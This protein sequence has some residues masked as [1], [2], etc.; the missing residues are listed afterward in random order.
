MKNIL[1]ILGTRP[2]AIKLA[3]VILE[4]QGQKKYHITICNTEQQKELSNQTLGFFGIQA[5]IYLDCM[6]PNQSLANLQSKILSAL[7][8]V[9]QHRVYHASI[10]Q[11]D[12]MSAFCGAL[13]SFY[14]HVPLFHVEAGL[15][16][17][18]M[19]EPFPEE[20]LRQMISK[21]ATLHFTPTNLA[22]ALL[23]QEGITAQSIIETG[24]T[25]LDALFCLSEESLQRAKKFWEQ[26]GIPLQSSARDGSN[27]VLITTHRRENHG[28]RLEEI[29]KAIRTLA[30]TF[31]NHYFIIPVHPNPNVKQRIYRSLS[32][33]ANILLCEPLDYPNLVLIMQHSKL[34]LTD[35]GGIQEEAPSFGV[36]IL[37]MRHETERKE[38][39]Q[40][41]FAKLVGT[42]SLCIVKE[43]SEILQRE[44]T[45][46]PKPNPYGNGEARVKIAQG[47]DTFFAPPPVV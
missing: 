35:S 4:L 10:V 33:F 1:I 15:R 36:P 29:L 23:L 20:A 7:E 44:T 28:D 47:I 38:G 18:N 37:V 16:S 43:S 22:T 26:L 11:G 17:Y 19:L 5:D 8:S 39:I 12:T 40:A 31:A 25:V 24:N 27:I 45:R 14:Y 2:E 9:F 42:D 6:S 46:I 32:K 3:P 13:M 21:I 34:I 30:E 41:G